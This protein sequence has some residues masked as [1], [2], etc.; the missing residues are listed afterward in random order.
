LSSLTGRIEAYYF[1]G[2]LS[3]A[4]G[5][6]GRPRLGITTGDAGH[7]GSRGVRSTDQKLGKDGRVTDPSD[8]GKGLITQRA[9]QAG[10]AA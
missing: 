1:C 10:C 5:L 7:A 8:V 3:P 6:G 2:S 4:L 9:L